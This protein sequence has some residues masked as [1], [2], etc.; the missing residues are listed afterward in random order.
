LDIDPEVLLRSDIALIPDETKKA[1]VEAILKKATRLELFDDIGLRRFLSGLKHASLAE[2]LWTYIQDHAV[3]VIVR[4]LALEIAEDC[5]LEELNGRLLAIVCDSSWEQQIRER[6]ARVLRNTLP[7]DRVNELEALGRG[8]CEPDE[9][10]EMKGH[11][12]YRLIPNHWSIANALQYLTPPKHDHFHGTYHM[13]L[14]YEAPKR[15]VVE[16]LPALLSWLQPIEHCFDILSPFSG[17]ASRAVTLA[18]ENLQQPEI[19]QAT[20]RLWRAKRRKLESLSSGR[21]DD[22]LEALLDNDSIR[23]AFAFAVFDDAETTEDDVAHLLLDGLP[24]LEWHDLSWVLQKLPSVSTK[25]LPVWTKVVV[26]LARPENIVSCWDLFLQRIRE[27][28][29]LQSRF[30]W[31]REWDINSVESRKAKAEYLRGVRRRHRWEGQHNAPDPKQLIAADL[32]EIAKGNYWQWV[33]LSA[34]LS[35]K[36]GNTHYSAYLRHDVT[37]EPGWQTA[38]EQTPIAIRNSAKQFLLHHKDGYQELGARTNYCDPGYLA[39]WLLRD[40]ISTDNTLQAAISKNWIG[41]IVGYF[42]NA[43]DHYQQMVSLAYKL[44]PDAT[45]DALRREAEESFDRNG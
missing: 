1:V 26:W 23:R 32:Q 6:A 7:A 39:I 43:E 40:E 8:E 30:E 45:L 14:H 20:V 29:N 24:L 34:H 13:F 41:S 4:R 37:Q 38:D 33:N 36:P 10:D 18:L 42:N 21:R 15:I 3:N 25:Q 9:D 12:L 28:P 22:E 2:Q 31:L 11:A 17:L 44:N 5:R 19:R 16:D 35:L 27:I